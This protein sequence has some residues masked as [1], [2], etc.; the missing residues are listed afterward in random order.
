M[1]SVFCRGCGQPVS[2]TASTCPNC[3]APQSSGQPQ[4]TKED[5]STSAKWQRRFA[6]IQKAGGPKLS[7]LSKLPISDRLAVKFNVWGFLF[8]PFYYA[9]LGMWKRAL[10]LFGVGVAI[11]LIGQVILNAIGANQALASFFVAGFFAG[12]VNVDYFKKQ[13]LNDNGWW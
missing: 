8:G 5:T 10:S 9:F 12:K 6:L 2:A 7:S 3:G 11:V 4:P 1:S 13:V